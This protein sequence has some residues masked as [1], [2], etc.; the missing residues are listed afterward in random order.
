MELK[1][2][3]MPPGWEDYYT[4]LDAEER[5]EIFSRLMEELPDDGL[6]AFRC[7]VYE[8]R[9]P[10]GKKAKVK[11][12]F[13]LYIVYFPGLYAKKT[14]FFSTV[15]KE[16]AKACVD[17]GLDQVE[18]LSE[19]EKAI[20]YWELHNAADLYFSTCKDA[21]YGR[22]LFGMMQSD[23]DD[24]MS[25]VCSEAWILVRGI[26]QIGNKTAEMQLFSDAVLDAYFHFDKKAERMFSAFDE[27]Q[28][29]R[30]FTKKKRWK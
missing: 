4:E 9:Y 1:K 19:K 16:I 23:D 20:V 18:H 12:Q 29:Q 2:Y 6:D 3:E 30:I 25:Q 7:E 13:L 24:R 21:G 8:R 28:K 11:D 5:K 14:S 15:E 10:S 27:K 26:P 22:K 17:L